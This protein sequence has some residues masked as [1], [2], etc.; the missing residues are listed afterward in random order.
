MYNIQSEWF[1][2]CVN[3]NSV[4][5]VKKFNNPFKYK[6]GTLNYYVCFNIY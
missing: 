4:K 3:I 5:Y 1:K 6:C 2:S